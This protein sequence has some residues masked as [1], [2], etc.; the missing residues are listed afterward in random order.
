M[1]PCIYRIRVTNLEEDSVVE[2]FDA[3]RSPSN[4]RQFDGFVV[5]GK[6]QL[7]NDDFAVFFRR[8][9]E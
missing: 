3:A 7:R 5:F 4:V 2:V 1:T 6:I 8:L 9:K